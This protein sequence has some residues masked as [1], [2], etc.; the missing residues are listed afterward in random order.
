M[1]DEEKEDRNEESSS[2]DSK[3]CFRSTETILHGSF[4]LL[5]MIS[6]GLIKLTDFNPIII[7]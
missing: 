3:L 5:L 1:D 7:L 2:D 4:F 6:P